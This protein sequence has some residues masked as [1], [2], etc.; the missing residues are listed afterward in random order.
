M[1]GNLIPDPVKFPEGI[2]AVADYVHSVG[3]RFG[4]YTSVGPRTCGGY[5][6]GR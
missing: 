5:S 3:A 1:Q 6:R 4:I 2:K